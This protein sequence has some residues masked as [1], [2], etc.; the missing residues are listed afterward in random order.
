MFLNDG[1]FLNC[2]E[3][4]SSALKVQA[5]SHLQL[6]EKSAIV[7]QYFNWSGL[8]DI[9]L[10]LGLVLLLIYVTLHF[11]RKFNLSSTSDTQSFKLK[12]LFSSGQQQKLI[13][14]IDSFRVTANTSLHVIQ[15]EDRRIL[16]SISGQETKVLLDLTDTC[17]QDQEKLILQDQESEDNSEWMKNLETKK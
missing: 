11:V 1:H 8:L 3:F 15:V 12:N 7:D 5:S 10:K 9:F 6:T 4:I 16:I 14:Q 17:L 2:S 13:S